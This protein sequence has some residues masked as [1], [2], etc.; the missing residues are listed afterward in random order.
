[1][2][3]TIANSVFAQMVANEQTTQ[4]I[5]AVN[6]TEIFQIALQKHLSVSDRNSIISRLDKLPVVNG[7]KE[8]LLLL[9]NNIITMINRPVQ[10][11]S[12]LFLYIRCEEQQDKEIMDLRADNGFKMYSICLFTNMSTDE[13]WML[14]HKEKLEECALLVQKNKGSFQ[15]NLI[16]DSGCLFSLTFP[17]KLD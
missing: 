13:N 17:G 8:Q 12:K 16:T 1:M 2:N 14:L 9:C 10:G 3:N 4:L 11:N 5:E 7:N 15:Y 6:L